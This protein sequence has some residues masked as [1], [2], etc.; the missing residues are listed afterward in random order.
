MVSSDVQIA[1][2]GGTNSSNAVFG[3]TWTFDGKHWTDRQDIGPPAAIVP[4]H[5]IRHGASC[6]RSVRRP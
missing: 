2:F 6:H 5:G 4:C 1:L 3:D